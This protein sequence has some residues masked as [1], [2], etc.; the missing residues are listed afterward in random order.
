MSE[1][2]RQI[3]IHCCECDEYLI[4]RKK[5]LSN[6]KYVCQDCYNELIVVKDG[7]V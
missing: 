6:G 1:G 5:S 3:K 2:E 4:T 7:K